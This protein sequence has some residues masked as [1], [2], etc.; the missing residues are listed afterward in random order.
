MLRQTLKAS[1]AAVCMLGVFAQAET[2]KNPEYENWARFKPGAMVKHATKSLANG[3]EIT[4]TTTNKLIEITPEKLVV[5]LSS[6]MEM[7][8][9]K[10]DS[11]PMKRDVPA[12]MDKAI[13]ARTDPAQNPDMKE[14]KET[15][16][17]AGK[18]FDCKVVIYT[19]EAN[20]MK[21]VSKSWL[22]NDVPGGLV[23][24]EVKTTGSVESSTE[25]TLVEFSTGE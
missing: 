24:T 7:S 5:E 20:G 9:Q 1:L 17:V 16:T 25:M 15:V 13:V 11:P 19:S 6:S 10:M 21:S 2:V 4:S 14:E 8:G 12:E 18:K 22:C 3:Q 23:K